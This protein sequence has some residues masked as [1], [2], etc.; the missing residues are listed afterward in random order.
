M[1]QG[2]DSPLLYS[3]ACAI[4]QFHFINRPEKMEFTCRAKFRYRQP[5]QLVSVLVEGD[6]VIVEAADFQRAV[7][8]G[9]YAVL[10]NGNEC[11]GGGE[12]DVI[13]G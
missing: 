13:L 12:I 7:T 2:A 1:E 6:S 3:R 8:P 5:D 10:Y 11:L 9:Q 4:N